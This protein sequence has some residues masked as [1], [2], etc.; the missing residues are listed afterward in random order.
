MCEEVEL[1]PGNTKRPLKH[2]GCWVTLWF[3]RYGELEVLKHLVLIVLRWCIWCTRVWHSTAE[4]SLWQ[5]K[6]THWFASF[7]R[8]LYQLKLYFFDLL[9]HCSIPLYLMIRLATRRFNKW[10]QRSKF[11][12]QTI[13]SSIYFWC[14]GNRNRSW[15]TISIKNFLTIFFLTVP[16]FWALGKE[17]KCF[18]EDE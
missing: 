8:Y 10:S 15:E 2:N 17:T 4:R 11:D 7:K 14:C 12:H 3:G 6:Q 13:S 5:K 9:N 16:R 1:I 18:Q